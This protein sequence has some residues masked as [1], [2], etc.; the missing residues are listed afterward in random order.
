MCR[1]RDEIVDHLLWHCDTAHELWTFISV[2]GFHWVISKSVVEL[3]N[4]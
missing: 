2:F 3:L 4:S 1:S